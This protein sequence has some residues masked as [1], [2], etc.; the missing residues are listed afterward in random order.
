MSE[1]MLDLHLDAT[2]Q[3]LYQMLVSRLDNVGQESIDRSLQH[4]GVSDKHHHNLNEVFAAINSLNV[5]N[6]VK[7]DARAIYGILAEAEAR[8]HGCSVEETHFHEVGNGEAIKNVI[9]ICLA[10]EVLNPYRIVATPVQ[11]GKGKVKC[12]HGL[13][14]IPAPATAAIIERGIPV[15]KEKIEGEWCTPTSAAV[16][17]HFVD[18][19]VE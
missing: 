13:L 16:I 15:A 9:G 11:T 19:F 3:H 17:Y 5:S 10:I 6:Q 4:A 18:D 12:A 14:D 7:H 8:V 2:R 1:L